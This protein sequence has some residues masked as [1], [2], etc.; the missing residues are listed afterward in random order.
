MPS[1]ALLSEKSAAEV[2]CVRPKTL[3]T[4][5]TMG[6]GPAFVRVGSAIR[7]DPADLQAFV[8]AGRAAADAHLER[9]ASGHG[10]D[11]PKERRVMEGLPDDRR[12]K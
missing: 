9:R 2:L 12:N 4:W 10:I 8:D 5:R 11:S 1:I 6:R 7:Y 3:T